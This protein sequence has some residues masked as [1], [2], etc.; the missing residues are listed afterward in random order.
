MA[1]DDEIERLRTRVAP[2]AKFLHAISRTLEE[3]NFS[4]SP[5][6]LGFRYK[7]AQLIHFCLLRGVR[8]VSALNASVE[9]TRG[10]Y[11][12]EIGVILRTMIEYASQIDFMLASLDEKG[13]LST[14]AARF[15]EDFFA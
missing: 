10:G 13:K 5:E 4:A 9:L 2:L 3:P 6:H 7:N 11:S 1:F 15:L 8:I 12:Q 14:K